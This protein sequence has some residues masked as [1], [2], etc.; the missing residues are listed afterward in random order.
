MLDLAGSLVDVLGSG[1]RVALATVIRTWGPTPQSTGTRMAIRRGGNHL[2][3]IGGGCAEAE[4]I[5]AGLAVLDSGVPRLVR[6]D[7]TEDVTLGSEAACGGTMEVLVAPWDTALLPVLDAM[8][9]KDA[10]RRQLH[11]LTCLSP[12]P[13]LGA[14][15]VVSGGSA[16]AWAGLESE[17]ARLLAKAAVETDTKA[18]SCRITVRV[19]PCEFLVLWE[20]VQAVPVLLVCGGGH[21]ALPLSQMGKLLG[22]S[23]VVVDDRPSFA[24]PARFPWADRVICGPF[25]QSLATYPTDRATYAVVVTRG[26]RHDLE[27]VQALLDRDTGYMGM[28]GSRRR[29]AGV[30]RLLGQEGKAGDAL[31]RLH[32]PTGL[33]IGAQSPA[34]IALSILAEITKVRRGG[35]GKSLSLITR[36]GDGGG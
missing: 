19:G 3:T 9:R 13:K 26:H 11:C 8:S 24:N 5:R 23:V 27:C 10:D 32:A 31:A 4:V 22:F 28:I 21:I 29:V 18:G 36:P 1:E 30:L 20:E 25:A 14:M 33:D 7:L 34:E 15:I 12:G 6:A 17:Q 35:S 16:A 2:G